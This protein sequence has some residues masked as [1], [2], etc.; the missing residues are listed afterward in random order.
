MAK[1]YRGFESTS[2][3]QLVLTAENTGQPLYWK[4]RNGPAFRDKVRENRTSE[5]ERLR[6]RCHLSARFLSSLQRQSGFRFWA[7]RTTRDH[8]P[9]VW[10]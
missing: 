4:L 8:E 7:G 10:L 1:P 9:N 3:R 6:R 5:S 2:L